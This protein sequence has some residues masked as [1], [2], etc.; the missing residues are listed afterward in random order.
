MQ[1]LIFIQSQPI[2]W[3][4]AL[5]EPLWVSKSRFWQ[6]KA[7]IFWIQYTHVPHAW[8]GLI[9]LYHRWF[10]KDFSWAQQREN[11]SGAQALV[12]L[13]SFP[14]SPSPSFPLIFDIGHGK[15]VK[16]WER[17]D[18]PVVSV[19]TSQY[20]FLK[21]RQASRWRQKMCIKCVYVNPFYPDFKIVFHF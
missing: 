2:V 6:C 11:V 15:Q 20:F 4:L 10:S 9:S 1:I 19:G 21:T 18:E 16:A 7:K 14:S 5:N 12:S 13:F 17:Q 3:K 8:R